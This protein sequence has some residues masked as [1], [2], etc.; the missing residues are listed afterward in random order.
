MDNDDVIACLNNLIEICKDGEYGFHTSAQHL[1]NPNTRRLFVTRAEA[2]GTA[3]AQLQSFVRALGGKA[4]DSGTTVG[5]MHRG[6]V[7]VKSKLV[8]Y[9]DLDILEDTER[10]EDK[11]VAAYRDALDRDLPP[12]VRALVEQQYL[13]AQRNHDQ[14]RALRDQAR[15]VRA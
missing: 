11:A 1:R 6:W 4:E 7:A 9:T 12:D 10:A 13:G 3:A 8:E 5:A 15:A 14:V 2:C